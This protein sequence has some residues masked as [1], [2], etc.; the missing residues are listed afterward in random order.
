MGILDAM[1][2][3]E[4]AA[5]RGAVVT[6]RQIRSLC[7][8]SRAE[9]DARVLRMARAGTLALHHHDWPASLTQVERD[10]LVYCDGVYYIGLAIRQYR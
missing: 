6:P 7:G 5:D 3:V 9:F 10:E 2:S 1:R 4:P 8:L